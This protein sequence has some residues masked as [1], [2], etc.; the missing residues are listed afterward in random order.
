MKTVTSLQDKTRQVAV[1]AALKG[2]ADSGHYTEGAY[3]FKLEKLFSA[4]THGQFS[5]ALNSRGSALYTLFRYYAEKGHRHIAL[6]NNSFFAAGA[7]AIEAGMTVHLVDSGENTPAMGVD[8]LKQVLSRE[9]ALKLVMLTHVGGWM[10]ED[11]DAI[12]NLCSERDTVLLE[13]CSNVLGLDGGTWRPGMF[14]EASVWSLHP[15]SAVPVGAA[16]MICTRDGEVRNFARLFRSYGKFMRNGLVG[17]G[18][19][20]DFRMSE[21]EASVA[22]IQLENLNSIIAARKRDAAALQSIATCLLKGASNYQSYPVDP[23]QANQRQIAPSIHTFNDQLIATLPKSKV[24][25]PNLVHSIRWAKNHKCLPIGE[26]LYDGKTDKEIQL[27][28]KRA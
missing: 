4:M 21:W 3:V 24:V 15:G 22:C 28:L 6:Q 12:T 11:Y 18:S 5:A 13:D 7:M 23:A 19:G 26:G 9:K 2:V 14:G 10:A 8:S 1:L 16:G 25:A 17:Y 20:F 27:L